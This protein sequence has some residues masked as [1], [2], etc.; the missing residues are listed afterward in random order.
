[1]TD[2]KTQAIDNAKVIDFRVRVPAQLCPKI[3][4]PQEN[5]TQYD[6]VLAIG[7]KYQQAQ[8]VDD[9]L[10]QMDANGVDHAIV[11]AEHEHGD[12]ADELNRAV[13]DMVVQ[14]PDRFTGIGTV[15]LENF[16]IKRALKQI[17]DCVEL[18]M[19]GL[20]IEPA[21]FN[22]TLD[23][24]KLYP[25]Y[26]KA[27]ENNLL[28]ALHTGINY[29]TH[30]PMAGENPILLDQLACDFPDLTIVASHG[31]WPW[32]NEMVA[33]AR[34]HPQVF[35][36]F[37]GIAPKYVAAQGGGWEV[38]HRFMNSVLKDQVLYGT[39][40]PTMDHKRT[41]AEWREMDLK[42][43]VLERLLVGNA[44]GLL[45]NFYDKI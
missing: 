14:H 12:V 32:I 34:K 35:I 31:G 26:A 40:W 42:P 16:T 38:M 20:S 44:R 9:L 39:D 45:K 2:L 27:M 1:M 5:K 3:E 22:M 4:T 36:E 28:V 24:K 8:T 17:E 29:T 11:H 33:V 41:L 43:E 6:A 13:A 25:I 15:S 18:G 7:D 30:Q 23:E 37:G 19:I 10:Q 21:F